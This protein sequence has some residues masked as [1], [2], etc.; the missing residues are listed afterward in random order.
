MPAIRI[1]DIYSGVSKE[2][3]TYIKFTIPKKECICWEDYEQKAAPA[4]ASTNA[5]AGAPRYT[6]K[7]PEFH[8]ARL[9]RKAAEIRPFPSETVEKAGEGALG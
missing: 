9:A 8:Q 1:G 4:P 2:A 6:P 3:G 7:D 5:I